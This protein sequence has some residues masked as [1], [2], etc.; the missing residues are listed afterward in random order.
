[1]DSTRREDILV[2]PEG[3]VDPTRRKDIQ[4]DQWTQQREKIFWWTLEDQ[5][6]QQEEKT[7]WWTSGQKTFWMTNGLSEKTSKYTM[8][9]YDYSGGN[10]TCS[11]GWQ[12]M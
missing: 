2:D 12:S 3:P 9:E 6:T 5:W 4:V 1:M 8:H 10:T 7:F 11:G